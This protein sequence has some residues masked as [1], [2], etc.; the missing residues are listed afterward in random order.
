MI[1]QDII[2]LYN[3][4]INC[5]NQPNQQNCGS[6]KSSPNERYKR[7]ERITNNVEAMRVRLNSGGSIN[8]TADIKFLEKL[9]FEDQND[10]ATAG[11]WGKIL[12]D[13]EFQ[14]LISDANFIKSLEEVIKNPGATTGERLLDDIV[15]VR[16][17]EK[18]KEKRLIVNRI[19]A[20]A[21]EEVSAVV[22]NK[23]FSQI[24]KALVFDQI[25]IDG[26][27]NI[28][29]KVRT[30]TEWYGRNVHMLN[31]FKTIIGGTPDSIV[32]C[33]FP[34]TIYE[35]NKPYIDSMKVK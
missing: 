25:I 26:G 32:L 13:I 7:Y 27:Y 21:T 17:Q 3:H 24:F 2:D 35:N 19:I 6:G 9:I 8:T 29:S 23:Q 4:F 31:Q 34:I 10:I 22:T 30:I 28:D 12:T 16:R 5:Y 18:V 1:P 11:Q 20:A 14:S 33:K 15:R